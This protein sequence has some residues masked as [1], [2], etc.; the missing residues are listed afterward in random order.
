[1]PLPYSI[2]YD[3]V[4]T[5]VDANTG[6]EKQVVIDSSTNQQQITTE[7]GQYK[8]TGQLGDGTPVT[9]LFT[10]ERLVY[11]GQATPPS[12]V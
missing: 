2:F 10:R 4:G 6:Y 5:I 1:M 11:V 8:T 12:G 7:L 9:N 3:L